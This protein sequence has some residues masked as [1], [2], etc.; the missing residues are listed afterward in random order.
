MAIETF[1]PE[2][3][4]E[5]RGPGARSCPSLP[6]LRS[7]AAG[8]A[9]SGHAAAG[10]H[11]SPAVRVLRRGLGTVRWRRCSLGR[12]R[13]PGTLKVEPASSPGRPSGARAGPGYPGGRGG[14]AVFFQPAPAT[15][16]RLWPDPS[17]LGSGRR[18]WLDLRTHRAGD[19]QKAQRSS[20]RAGGLGGGRGRWAGGWQQPGGAGWGRNPQRCP[21]PPW[22]LEESYKA[23]RDGGGGEGGGAETW[24]PVSRSLGVWT[25]S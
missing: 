17:S 14:R 6:G 23:T 24:N 9:G 10:A 18:G 4:P 8:A 16:D 5:S 21:P 15:L 11:A 25:E 1:N 3:R 7:L 12:P 19:F 2:L 13:V 20:S 22:L